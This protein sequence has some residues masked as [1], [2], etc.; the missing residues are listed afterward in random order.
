[1]AAIMAQKLTPPIRM[2]DVLIQDVCETGV[3]V[4]ATKTVE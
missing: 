1:M 4:I 2:G 3:N